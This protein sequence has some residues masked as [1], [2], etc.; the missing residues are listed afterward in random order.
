MNKKVDLH[1]IAER[2]HS[3][4]DTT[5]S[6]TG[7]PENLKQ[8]IVGF[9]DFQ[10]AEEFAKKYGL[11]ITIFFKKD[12][13]NLYFRNSYTITSAMNITAEDYGEN[14]YQYEK[15][16]A[17]NFF[18]DEVRPKL[19]NFNDIY[20][21]A[22]F[23]EYSKDTYYE[24]EW[25]SNDEILIMLDGKRYDIIEKDLMSWQHDSKEWRIGV[26]QDDYEDDF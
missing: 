18:E 25:L 13:W 8:A 9:E 19:N 12:G 22:K 23:V 11:R 3:V 17:E 26:I 1:T 14:Y 24:I 6:L 5:T 16:Q 15:G 7:Y 10:E 4:V 21:L 20:E 2:W